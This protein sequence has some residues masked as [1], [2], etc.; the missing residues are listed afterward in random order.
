MIIAVA[1]GK[2]GTGKTT[3]A[4]NLALVA[5]SRFVGVSGSTPPLL[6]DAASRQLDNAR[7]LVLDCDVE[8]PNAHLFLKPT[9][10]GREEV[11]LLVPEIDFD[12]CTFCGRCAQA[13]RYNALAVI[14][15]QVLVFSEL[16]HGCGTCSLVCPEDAIHEVPEVIGRIE[17]GTVSTSL[18]DLELAHGLLDIGRA[19]APPVIRQLKR[20]SDSDGLVII[21]ASPGTSCPV[22]EALKG[23]DF[24]LLVTEPTPFG[25]HDLKLMAQVARDE[26]DLP[27]GVV[28][29]RDGIGDDQVEKFCRSEDIPILMRI[30]FDRRIA[31]V[32]SEGGLIVE[33]L[34]QYREGFRELCSRIEQELG[35]VEA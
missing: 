5:A 12:R 11:A 8:A 13:C 16:C 20:R 2:G 35:R 25:L 6:E 31:E 27:V 29:N 28:I 21:D 14:K 9:F 26:L 15:E 33:A 19:L 7:P 10:T 1:S 18:G 22:V 23:A 17:E 30:P 32:Y 4:V 24:A 3:V 34:P